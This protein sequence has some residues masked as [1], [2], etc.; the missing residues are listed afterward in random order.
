MKPAT[1]DD[2]LD[3]IDGYVTS[4]ALGA[5]LELGLFWLLAEQPLDADGVAEV[6]QIPKNRCQYWLQILDSTGLIGQSFQGYEPTSTART[7]ILEAYSHETWAFLARE[8]REQYPGVINL[9]TSIQ[10]VGSA[11][12]IQKLTPPN[13]FAQISVDPERALSFTRMLYE[14]HQPLADELA[15]ALDLRNVKKLMDLGGGSGVVS[16]ALLQQNPDL[17]VVVVDIPSVCAAGREIAKENS[18]EG[19]LTYHEA[20]FLHNDLPSGFDMFLACDVGGYREEILDL[21]K[22]V[23]V[24]GGRVVLVEQYATTP[25]VAPLSHMYWAFLDS[26]DDPDF[27]MLTSDEVQT[28]IQAAGFRI[29]SMCTLPGRE[30]KRWTGDWIMIEAIKEKVRTD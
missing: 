20:N 6:L 9:A 23:L 12:A 2:V 7:A 18:M 16:L 29:R 19:M 3:L 26:M 8:A 24:D 25:G 13:Y 5:A 14:I 4:A 22:S 15:I 1:T 21:A 17:N 27:V 10:E 30:V 11:W 28:R